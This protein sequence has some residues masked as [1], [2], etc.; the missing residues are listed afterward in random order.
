VS[1]EERVD[2]VDGDDRVLRRVTRREIREGN[3][4][5]RSVYIL[6]FNTAGALFVHRRTLSKDVFPGHWDVAVGGVVGAGEAYDEAARRELHEEVG[7]VAVPVR[8]LFQMRYEDSSSRLLG[9]VYACTWDGPMRLQR[10][11]VDMGEW[12]AP[13]APLMQSQDRRYCPD[14]LL[15]LRRYLAEVAHTR[16]GAEPTSGL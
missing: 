10:S 3:L 7:I 6:V 1:A 15:A 8:P 11:E 16:P 2:V 9:R 12:V 4:L 14:G 13:T 5:H